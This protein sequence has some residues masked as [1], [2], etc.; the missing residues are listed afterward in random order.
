VGQPEA[1][2]SIEFKAFYFVK[3]YFCPSISQ[4]WIFLFF[5]FGLSM[6]LLVFSSTMCVASYLLALVRFINYSNYYSYLIDRVS[7]GRFGRCQ[8]MFIMA[9]L[10]FF[11]FFFFSPWP[12]RLPPLSH[13]QVHTL[14]AESRNGLNDDDS[15]QQE[16]QQ[17]QQHC[18]S[19]C[20]VCLPT[21]IL[22]S[23]FDT[24]TPR[25]TE[26]GIPFPLDWIDL[27]LLWI[28]PHVPRQKPKQL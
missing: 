12:T 9:Q 5:L 28:P 21:L 6:A 18:T 26:H 10:C 19:S 1:N 24:L 7:A 14:A 8:Q 23:A 25:S 16:Q 15:I 4:K 2:N 20:T 3:K 17:Q 27:S 13:T 11:F 22:S